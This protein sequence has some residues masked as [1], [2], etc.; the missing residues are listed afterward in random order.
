VPEPETTHIT[1][2]IRCHERHRL[3]TAQ[4]PRKVLTV[5]EPSVLFT[6]RCTRCRVDVEAAW[7][8]AA[9][10]LTD[11]DVK[12]W[13]RQRRQEYQVRCPSGKHLLG[14]V[15]LPVKFL[16]GNPPAVILFRSRC[17]TCKIEVEA[18]FT[19]AE[20]SNGLAPA[21]S[22]PAPPALPGEIQAVCDPMR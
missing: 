9:E 1:L 7:C 18:T 14:R 16:H 3:A 2:E 5:S 4:M 8:P 10:A 12:A 20:E 11:E 13:R 19:A 22:N 17:R 21:A 15:S 6:V